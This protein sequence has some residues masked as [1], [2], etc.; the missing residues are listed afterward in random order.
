MVALTP[1]IAIQILGLVYKI[2]Q[3]AAKPV[4]TVADSVIV[5]EDGQ[6]IMSFDTADH[7]AENDT[8]FADTAVDE[9]IIDF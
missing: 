3:A 1:L 6:V 2:K 8:V 4:K 9:D 7:I 5:D